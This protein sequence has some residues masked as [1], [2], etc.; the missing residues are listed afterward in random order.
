[1]GEFFDL[2]N[3]SPPNNSIFKSCQFGK[4]TIVQFRAKEGTLSKPLKIV[5]TNL[6]GPMRKKYPHGEQ[7][8]KLFIDNFTRIYFVGLLK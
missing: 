1:M 8:F 7:Y 6:Y 2:P 3:I 5:H 4:K